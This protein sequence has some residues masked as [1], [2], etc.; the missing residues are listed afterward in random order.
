[1]NLLAL[2]TSTT[3]AAV[4]LL[5]RSGAVRVAPPD[6]SQRHGRGLLPAIRDLLAAAGLSARDLDAVAVGLGPG[7]FTGLRVGVTAAKTLAYATGC[8]L[9]GLDSLA[10]FARAAPPDARR[11]A[12]AGD[13]QRGD[14]FVADFERGESGGEWRRIGETRLEPGA[15]WAAALARGTA[16]VGPG[17]GRLRL[18]FP[19]GVRVGGPGAEAPDPRALLEVALAAAATGRADDRYALEPFYI[20]RSAAEEKATAPASRPSGRSGGA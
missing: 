6:P 13:A 5:D 19:E 8:R 14:V 1:V 10:V 4:A 3:A 2:E 15:A 11:V 18:E 7:S 12:V 20:R 16:V 9:I 17:L